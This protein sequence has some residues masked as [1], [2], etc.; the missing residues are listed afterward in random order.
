M[1]FRPLARK[2][3]PTFTFSIK[4]LLPTAI[5]PVHTFLWPDTATAYIDADPL[6]IRKGILAYGIDG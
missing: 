5:L 1:T 6:K 2:L 3:K 4:G